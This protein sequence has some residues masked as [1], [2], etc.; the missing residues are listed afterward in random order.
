MD[1]SGRMVVGYIAG[2]ILIPKYVSQ[3]KAL[4]VSTVT[5]IAGSLLVVLTPMEISIFFVYLLHWELR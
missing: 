3:S 5:A 2:I 1:C 4:V